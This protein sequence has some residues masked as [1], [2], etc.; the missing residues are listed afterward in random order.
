VVNQI[1]ALATDEPQ[2]IQV[3]NLVT[4]VVVSLMVNVD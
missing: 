2:V 4:E 1:V 3:V